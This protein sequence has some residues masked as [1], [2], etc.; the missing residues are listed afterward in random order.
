MHLTK[1]QIIDLELSLDK[2]SAFEGLKIINSNLSGSTID[3]IEDALITVA[4]AHRYGAGLKRDYAKAIQHLNDAIKLGS[5]NAA[6]EL[7]NI[8]A[9]DDWWGKKSYKTDAKECFQIA[10][11]LWKKEVSKGSSSAAWEIYNSV[12]GRSQEEAKKWSSI[13]IEL[14]KKSGDSEGVTFM[15][16]AYKHDQTR[17]LKDYDLSGAQSAI[18]GLEFYFGFTKDHEDWY[19]GS[20]DREQDEEKMRLYQKVLSEKINS[21]TRSFNEEEKKEIERLRELCQKEV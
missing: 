5:G 3:G 1:E 8:F 19:V 21:I 2:V 15:Q 20:H 17:V 9:Y 16:G 12:K 10:I 4:K 13:A 6:N 14:A 11:N 18:K 7:G